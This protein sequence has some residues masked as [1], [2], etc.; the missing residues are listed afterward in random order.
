MAKLHSFLALSLFTLAFNTYTPNARPKCI[1]APV[2]KFL[3]VHPSAVDVTTFSRITHFRHRVQWL[4]D[5]RHW[6]CHSSGTPFICPR[7]YV[8]LTFI[9]QSFAACGSVLL[10]RFVSQEIQSME[11]VGKLWRGVTLSAAPESHNARNTHPAFIKT[12]HHLLSRSIFWKLEAHGLCELS[13]PESRRTLL[14]HPGAPSLWSDVGSW[15]GLFQDL[16]HVD[17]GPQSRPRQ[18]PRTFLTSA[19]SCFV[20][21]WHNPD[22]C[23]PELCFLRTSVG[24]CHC[25]VTS[26]RFFFTSRSVVFKTLLD[27][28]TQIGCINVHALDIFTLQSLHLVLS[29]LKGWLPHFQSKQSSAISRLPWELFLKKN[30]H[31]IYLSKNRHKDHSMSSRSRIHFCIFRPTSAAPVDSFLCRTPCSFPFPSSCQRVLLS[32]LSHTMSVLSAMQTIAPY[33]LYLRLCLAK[34]EDLTH[35]CLAPL[36]TLLHCDS[37]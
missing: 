23:H 7:M 30:V 2:H 25:H 14:G 6:V 16:L 12:V 15:L 21:C 22:C 3:M 35:H 4:G 29:L 1:E 31:L 17:F 10:A 27:F 19:V 9:L 37:Q 18:E 5:I 32:A 33:S 8:T 13:V 24:P 36:L 11:R 28:L 20:P 34:H 26:F